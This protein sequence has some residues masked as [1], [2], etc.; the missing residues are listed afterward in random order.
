MRTRGVWNWNDVRQF[1]PFELDTFARENGAYERLRGVRTA[2]DFVRMLLMCALPGATFERVSN[3]ISDAGMGTMNTQAVFFRFRDN[4]PF[5]EKLLQELLKQTAPGKL[6]YGEYRVLAS[7]ATVAC[8]PGSKGTDQRLHALY[9]LSTWSLLSIE[10]TGPGVGE[11]LA[12]HTCLGPG[13]LILA[14]RGYGHTRGLLSA[15]DSG[16]AL[17]VRFEFDSIK[18][19]TE[20]GERITPQMATDLASQNVITQLPVRLENDSRTLRAIATQRPDGKAVWLITNLSEQELPET[21]ARALYRQRWQIELF[22][23]RMKSLLKLDALPTRN[24]P[25]ARSWILAKLILATLAVGVRGER[26]SPSDERV[27]DLRQGRLDD[28]RDDS[29]SPLPT[30]NKTPCKASPQTQNSQATLLL[31]V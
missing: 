4:A 21:Q 27:E 28:L 20:S 19:F 18:L 31:E 3:W 24:G 6:A 8:G 9:D 7:D 5:L 13:D 22:F 25:T 30:P 23:K 11:S 17:L 2:D 15:L 10:V 26:F 14:D 29:H 12:N 1:L 16:A